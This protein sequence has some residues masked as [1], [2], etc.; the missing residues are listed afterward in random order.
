MRPAEAFNLARI[1]KIIVLLPCLFD[2]E[3]PFEGLKTYYFW[4]L[5]IVKRNF[6]PAMRIE[7]CTPALKGCF[8]N[9]KLLVKP[10]C[11]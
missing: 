8:V 11:K 5:N 9:G 6:W 7:L 3:T 1:A 4:P 2:I 10:D